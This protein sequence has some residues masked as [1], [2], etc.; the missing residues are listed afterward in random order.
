M[1]WTHL[2]ALVINW[3]SD[4]QGF[5]YLSFSLT[6]VVVIQCLD[7]RLPKTDLELRDIYPKLNDPVELLKYLTEDIV[8]KVVDGLWWIIHLARLR[9]SELLEVVGE[10]LDIFHGESVIITKP[11]LSEVGRRWPESV[12]EV[13]LT[14][15]TERCPFKPSNN[16]LS[17]PCKNSF[18]LSASPLRTR[19][20]TFIRLRTFFC[21]TT[22]YVSGWASKISYISLDLEWESFSYPTSFWSA[23]SSSRQRTTLPAIQISKIGIVL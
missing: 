1:R 3:W 17:A 8:N 2:I 22:W 21:G 16:L 10:S 13:L 7:W 12:E 6:H 9:I 23:C 4:F 18:S 15:P 11:H 14:P 20:Q 5:P 19:K